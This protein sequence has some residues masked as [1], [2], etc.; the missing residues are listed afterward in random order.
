M[1]ILNTEST[2]T[3]KMTKEEVLL[4]VKAVD[5]A[6]IMIGHYIAKSVFGK[7][8]VLRELK[9]VSLEFTKILARL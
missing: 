1:D 8:T 2:I 9:P 7:Q 3:V 6:I 4:I 5:R